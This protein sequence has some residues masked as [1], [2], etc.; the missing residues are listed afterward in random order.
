MS[1]G[2]NIEY[3]IGEV[4]TL[5]LSCLDDQGQPSDLD[6]YTAEGWV[7]QSPRDETDVI[8]LAPTISDPA[9]GV[10]EVDAPTEG[11]LAGNYTWRVLLIDAQTNPIVIAGGNLK[12]RP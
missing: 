3:Y 8:D 4:I 1:D 5:R 10:V 6:G 2:A 12:L 7:R 11:V 9:S